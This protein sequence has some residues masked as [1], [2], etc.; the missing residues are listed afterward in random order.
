MINEVIRVGNTLTNIIDQYT[1]ENI[2]FNKVLKHSD[3]SNMNDAKCDGVIYRKLGNEYFRRN[4][5][6]RINVR[7][8]GAKLDNVNDDSQAIQKAIDSI[9]EG[10]VFIPEGYCKIG[11]KISVNRP[12]ITVEGAG[13]NKTNIIFTGT[14]EA[15]ESNN[16]SWDG[17]TYTPNFGTSL[18]GIIWKNFSISTTSNNAIGLRL[19]RVNRGSRVQSIN[20]INFKKA[21]I[22]NE[23]WDNG[24]RECIFQFNELGLEL[25]RENNGFVVFA[26][27]FSDNK[28]HFTLPGL[29]G[30]NRKVSFIGCSMD[31]I[32]EDG[33][34]Y[35]NNS[36]S[37]TLEGFY[38]EVYS[39]D[40]SLAKTKP[41]I[42]LGN[43]KQISITRNLMIS[44]PDNS[45]TGSWI[46]VTAGTNIEVDENTQTNGGSVAVEVVGGASVHI[47][48]NRIES[49]LKLN[50]ASMLFSNS[51]SLR[52]PI[53]LGLAEWKIPVVRVY[54]ALEI[55][56]ITMFF[57]NDWTPGGQRLR[58]IRQDNSD[59]VF[60]SQIAPGSLLPAFT[61]VVFEGSSGAGLIGAMSSG[62]LLLAYLY[63]VGSSIDVPGGTIIIDQV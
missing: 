43:V 32:G 39:S 36:E 63:K 49:Q 19:A 60:D 28:K 35:I 45:Y 56:R 13:I 15:L 58:I 53:A 20:F 26:C 6:D 46:K 21:M 9:F 27:V 25:D 50:N 4:S 37:V 62:V 30:T 42:E 5:Y 2:S 57:D 12:N 52:F 31:A 61:P 1:G 59:V 24:I 34:C 38:M 10:V 41:F 40:S 11:T 29:L 55:P 54:K 17:T 51:T 48:N 14:G 3:G 23:C 16:G 33:G 7:W 8:F 44:P 47:G 18:G 22:V